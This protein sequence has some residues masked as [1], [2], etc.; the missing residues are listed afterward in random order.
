MLLFQFFHGFD[1]LKIKNFRPCDPEEMV[2]RQR[3]GPS[4]GEIWREG[5]ISASGVGG[6]GGGVGEP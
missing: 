4:T 1:I 5:G 2:E 6:Q 3:G